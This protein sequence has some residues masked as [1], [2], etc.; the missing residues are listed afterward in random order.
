MTE[1]VTYKITVPL[2]T[3]LSIKPT[4]ANLLLIAT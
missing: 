4:Q 2:H 1:V 3:D